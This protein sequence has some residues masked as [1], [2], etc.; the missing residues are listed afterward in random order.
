M[1]CFSPPPFH[2]QIFRI[3][4]SE[5]FASFFALVLLYLCWF[6]SILARFSWDFICSL[7]LSCSRCLS[8]LIFQFG[9]AFPSPKHNV[10]DNLDTLV[11]IIPLLKEGKASEADARDLLKKLGFRYTEG[12]WPLRFLTPC[13][14]PLLSFIQTPQL[15]TY[16]HKS[17]AAPCC[18]LHP[19]PPIPTLYPPPLWR[20]DFGLETMQHLAYFCLL[21]TEGVGSYLD[22]LDKYGLSPDQDE[23]IGITSPLLLHR[24]DFVF[25]WFIRSFI[26]A[27]YDASS[28]PS[29]FLPSAFILLLKVAEFDRQCKRDA[30]L[31]AVIPSSSFFPPLSP[32]KL[33]R[34]GSPLELF[35]L[36]IP[37]FN[38][39]DESSRKP[40]LPL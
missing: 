3:C 38:Y 37:P 28:P 21:G 36:T 22:K 33:F 15:S 7:F 19:R 1:F 27:L 34:R 2:T 4:P 24:Y 14:R 13:P 11:P 16:P 9:M 20:S 40:L 30:E 18:P 35:S 31:Y 6:D 32:L 26:L 25:S 8:S 17:P 29:R 5:L 10:F 12:S 23:I 39:V